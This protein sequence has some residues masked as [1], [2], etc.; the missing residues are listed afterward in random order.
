MPKFKFKNTGVRILE[1]EDGDILICDTSIKSDTIILR[2][3]IR[4]AKT[5]PQLAE[6]IGRQLVN[7]V[8]AQRNARKKIAEKKLDL[9][10]RFDKRF[11][12][13]LRPYLAED[14]LRKVEKDIHFFL[15]TNPEAGEEI[16][17]SI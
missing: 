10:E 9:I 7:F 5:E 3:S 17:K 8:H 6:H 15:N 12:D 2:E 14:N 4:R 16:E 11:T 13:N 1:S